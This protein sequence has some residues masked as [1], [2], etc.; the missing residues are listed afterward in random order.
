MRFCCLGSGSKGNAT[1]VQAA[2]TTLLIDCGFSLKY[3]LSALEQKACVPDDLTAILVT[4][5]HSDHISGV[6]TLAKRYNIPVYLTPGTA[7]AQKIC[8]EKNQL[9]HFIADKPILIG[10]ILVKPVTVPHDAREPCQFVFS[11]DHRKLG[12]M[13]DLGSIS[14]YV[15]DQYSHCDALLLEA[16][17]DVPMLWAGP[18]PP[19][20]KQ[21]VIGDW[22][23]LS[24]EQAA[25]FLSNQESLPKL[26]VLGH[27]S[28]KNNALE[29]V[30][31]AFSCFSDRIDDIIYA[32]QSEGFSW[33]QV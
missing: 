21:R 1:L 3:M 5:E 18:Y 32:T 7:R 14:S 12:V 15:A 2:E 31:K 26:L 33:L 27:I 9:I 28:E 11:H 13:T 30:E 25:Q 24:N 29:K 19:S 20:L 23:H 10:D 22:G 4:H 6:N 17:H 16:N 8:S